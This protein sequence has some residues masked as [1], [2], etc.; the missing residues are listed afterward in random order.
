LQLAHQAYLR[1]Q[2][3]IDA[4]DGARHDDAADHFTAA[5]NSSAFSSKLKLNFHLLYEDLVVVRQYVHPEILS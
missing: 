2:L 4:F 5:I 3:G 1:I